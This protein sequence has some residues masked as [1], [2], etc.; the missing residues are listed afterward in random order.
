MKLLQIALKDVRLGLKNKTALLVMFVIPIL[1]LGLFYVMFGGLRGKETNTF[2]SIDLVVVNQDTGDWEKPQSDNASA[3]IEKAEKQFPDM[4]KQSM[5]S[6]LTMILKSDDFKTMFHTTEVQTP[7]EAIALVD[8]QKAEVAVI[9]PKEFTNAVFSSNGTAKVRLYQD[10][11]LHFS[12]MVVEEVIRQIIDGFNRS[13]IILGVTLENLTTEGL[14]DNE[15][16]AQQV[17]DAYLTENP[18]GK[19][20]GGKASASAM[21]DVQSPDEE[22]DNETIFTRIF[23]SM[24]VSLMAFYVFYTGVSTLNS[25][26]TEEE[27]G[28]LQRMISTPTRY[29]EI[30]G[31]KFVAAMVLV[32]VQMGVMILL[33]KYAFDV[34]WGRPLDFVLMFLG[35]VL[36]ASTFGVFLVSWAKTKKQAGFLLGGLVT[37]MGILGMIP[38]ISG[39]GAQSGVPAILAHLVPQGWV[40]YGFIAVQHGEPL[41]R[42]AG[43]FLVLLAWSVMFFVI[44]VMRF[45]RRYQ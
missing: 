35:T 45:K 44:G 25:V 20:Q 23:S 18:A 30:L 6:V 41:A 34:N 17:I 33:G 36:S 37:L 26:L 11:T 27:H 38:S 8:Q 3:L 4:G 28:T 22:K 7:A 2:P 13:K 10:P 29:R 32:S 21:V 14:V 5:G 1:M 16:T 42:I 43:F 19:A 40:T 24:I 31:G 9:I 12:P 39:G 15:E